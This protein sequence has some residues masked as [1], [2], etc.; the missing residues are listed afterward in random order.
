MFYKVFH[1]RIAKNIVFYKVFEGSIAET[2]CF[3]RVFQSKSCKPLVFLR[4]FPVFVEQGGGSG[5]LFSFD[6]LLAG[7]S[8]PR[9]VVVMCLVEHRQKLVVLKKQRVL[10][11]SQKKEK[12]SPATRTTWKKTPRT[13]ASLAIFE[14][15]MGFT[16]MFDRSNLID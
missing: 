5:F 10:S 1:W 7:S 3:Y 12:T 11:V 13:L 4:F 9:P 15:V 14:N 2:L 6:P 16:F 8:L